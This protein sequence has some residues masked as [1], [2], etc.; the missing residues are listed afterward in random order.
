M[1]IALSLD[2]GKWRRFVEEH[3]ASNIFHT[4][5]MFQVFAASKGH[6]PTLWAAQDDAEQVLALLLPVQ[7]TLRDGLAR[8]LT[9]RAVIYG[10]LLYQPGPAGEQALRVLLPSYARQAGRAALFTELRNLSDMSQAQPILDACGFAY[11]DHLNYL[12]N[13]ERSVDQVLQSIGPRTRKQI[14][15]G[16]RQAEVTVEQVA[17]RSQI[18]ACYALLQTTY[19]AARIPLADRSL[20]EAAFDILYPRGMVKFWL[21]RVGET[22]VATSVELLHKG[23]MLGWYGGVDRNFADYMPGELLMWHILAWG[24]Q[25]GYRTYDFGGAGKPGEKYGVRDFKAKFGGELVCFGRNTCVHAPGWLRLS[26]LGYRVYRWLMGATPQGRF[27]PA[28]ATARQAG[29]LGAPHQREGG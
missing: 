23:V 3:P 15:R 28:T 13:L 6:R 12:I 18:A 27:L 8:R 22:Y 4:P 5:E 11:E 20:F 24:V 16:L 7:L 9:T 21:A 14:R 17:D 26:Q 1:R 25:N 2:E 29:L 10:S 19:T